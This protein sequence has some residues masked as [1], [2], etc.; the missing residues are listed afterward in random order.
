MNLN[1]PRDPEYLEYQNSLRDVFL[2]NLTLD[3]IGHACWGPL[4]ALGAEALSYF[5]PKLVEFSMLGS[6]DKI[7]YPFMLRFVDAMKD[8]PLGSRL[9]LLGCEQQ[10][11]IL[12]ALYILRGLFQIEFKRH[13]CLEDL[14]LTIEMW[15]V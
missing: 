2:E 7:G 4:S 12:R 9:L 10:E 13:H 11:Y 3:I 1:I 8:A 6:K 14:D 15:K 5:M